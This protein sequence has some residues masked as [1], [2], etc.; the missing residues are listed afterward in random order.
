MSHPTVAVL[1]ASSTSGRACVDALLA[2]HAGLTTVRAI[3][4]SEARAAPLRALT[5]GRSDV[6]IVTGVDATDRASLR[7]AL[8]GAHVAFLVTPHA[9]GADMSGDAALV[10]NMMEV[11]A[12]VGVRHVL[13]GASWTVKAVAEIGVIASRF[14]PGEALLHK[15]K[16]ERGMCWTVLRGGF[17]DDGVRQLC[18]AT[19]RDRGVVAMPESFAT[20][21]CDPKDIGR[22]A[23]AVAAVGGSGH[24][25][26]VY[27]IS[28]P[29]MLTGRDV[30]AVLGTVLG[31]EVVY[32]AVGADEFLAPM[33]PFLRPLMAYMVREG[34]GAVPL[35]GDV[36]AVTGVPAVSFERW[37][38]EN[39]GLF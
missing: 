14:A 1:T 35:S 17:F 33:P 28:G 24:D 4:R 34:K 16:K 15:L 2:Q 39:R 11:A 9:P 18:S 7:R 30:A 36:E 31:K 3:F 22:V 10:A 5:A 19:V 23:A 13:F 26:K 25:E 37:A 12:D 20:P 6:E 27:E 21:A 38:T 29:E 32:E 8:D